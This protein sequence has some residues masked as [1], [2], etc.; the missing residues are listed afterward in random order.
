M[1]L[2]LPEPGLMAVYIQHYCWFSW[3]IY[4]GTSRSFR[5]I[6]FFHYCYSHH[7]HN[8]YHAILAMKFLL[9]ENLM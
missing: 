3:L 5:T 2:H 6:L 1:H 4:S 8:C 9:T 7:L